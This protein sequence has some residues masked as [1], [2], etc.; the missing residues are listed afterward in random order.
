M[1]DLGTMEKMKKRTGWQH[2]VED[3]RWRRWKMEKME[4]EEDGREGDDET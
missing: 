3:E 4:N 2:L 1:E